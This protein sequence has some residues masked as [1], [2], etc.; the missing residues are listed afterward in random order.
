MRGKLLKLNKK[1]IKSILDLKDG[2]YN[3]YGQRYS[4]IEI[5]NF[6]EFVNL[7]EKY[8]NI[9]TAP[10]I[11]PMWEQK[12]EFNWSNDDWD[13]SLEF[14]TFNKKAIFDCL[15]LKNQ[16]EHESGDFDIYKPIDYKILSEH[17]S[18]KIDNA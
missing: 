17:I 8:V 9:K 3:G 14:N 16:G 12:V 6:K 10:K 5:Q 2:W 7:F 15:N 11:Y 1:S 13:I 4:K 18:K